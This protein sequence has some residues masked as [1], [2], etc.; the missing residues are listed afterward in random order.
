M[1]ENRPEDGP[2]VAGS[3]QVPPNA[4]FLTTH[5]SQ[6]RLAGAASSP[7]ARQ[8]LEELCGAYWYPLYAFLR[9]GGHQEADAADLVQGFLASFL[10]LD[11]FA[12]A[13]EGHGRFRSYLLAALKHH[14]SH[15][16]EQAGAEK[17]GGGRRLL[18][19]ETLREA[20]ARYGRE[21]A[22]HETPETLFERRSASALIQKALGDLRREEE[23]RGRGPEFASLVPF[24]EGDPPEGGYARIACEL[25]RSEG[26]LKVAVHRLR[27]RWRQ[28]LLVEIA[29]QVER[30]QDVEGELMDLFRALGLPATKNAK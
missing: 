2:T 11:S 10:A 4:R 23:E 25:N 8:A 6:I 18:G 20:E 26:A 22:T 19:L 16:H 15:V 28:A 5:W 14:V 3:Q 9:R 7:Q 24:L 21:P 30:P 17:R 1:H 13:E 27:K 12:R 29:H